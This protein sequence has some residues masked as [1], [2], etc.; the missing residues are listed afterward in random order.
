MNENEYGYALQSTTR[1]IFKNDSVHYRQQNWLTSTGE[2]F[3]RGGGFWKLWLSG[4][5]ITN[6]NPLRHMH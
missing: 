4:M 6:L 5:R 2:S 1:N 3:I